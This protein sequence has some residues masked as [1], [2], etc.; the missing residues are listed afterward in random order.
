MMYKVV[1]GLVAV[2]TTHLTAADSRTRANHSFKFRT[3]RSVLE[4]VVCYLFII[5]RWALSYLLLECL[6][7][8]GGQ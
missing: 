7:T 3:I 5:L 2:P 1:H 4:I 8:Y 6:F